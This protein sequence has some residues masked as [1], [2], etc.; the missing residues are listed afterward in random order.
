[1]KKK[2]IW[3]IPVC[4]IVLA[5][6]GLPIFKWQQAEAKSNQSSKIQEVQAV[7]N[8]F[9]ATYGKDVKVNA[10]VSP[11]ELKIYGVTFTDEKYIHTSLCVNGVWV[12]IARIEIPQTVVPNPAPGGK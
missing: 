8:S 7:E 6:I 2:L 1:M 3:I 12:E 10:F 5:A 9:L 11:E 4:I